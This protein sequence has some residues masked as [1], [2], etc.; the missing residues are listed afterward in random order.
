M[1]F[2]HVTEGAWG[3]VRRNFEKLAGVLVD[4]GGR[5]VRVRFGTDTLSF[6]ASATS[7]TKTV[8]HGL[9]TTP[10]AAMAICNV[11]S[12]YIVLGTIDG[13]LNDETF[14]LAGRTNGGGS[15]TATPRFYWVALG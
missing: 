9:G 1:I 11:S 14:Q 7:A 13:S 2:E 4:T 5:L 3:T 8:T 12:D 15:I 6:S 10:V